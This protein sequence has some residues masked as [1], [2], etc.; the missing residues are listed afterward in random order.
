MADYE[1]HT[2]DP[3]TGADFDITPESIEAF[4]HSDANLEELLERIKQINGQLALEL[5]ALA[6]DYRSHSAN[7]STTDK[8]AFIK[9]FLTSI[10]L[11]EMQKESEPLAEIFELPAYTDEN[12]TPTDPPLSA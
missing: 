6:E 7:Q 4:R 10:K 5:Y 11:R 1:R 9:G 2:P 8:T 3:N 12:H